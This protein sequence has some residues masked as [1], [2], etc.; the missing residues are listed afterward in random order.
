M[1][2]QHDG[3]VVA[4]AELHPC[5]GPR[6][7]VTPL[8]DKRRLPV[9]RRRRNQHHPAAL[10]GLLQRRRGEVAP[11][12]EAG[13]SELEASTRG[14]SGLVPEEATLLIA[15][16]STPPRFPGQSDFGAGPR[17]AG[18]RRRH[19]DA[20][21]A[22]A[23]PARHLVLNRLDD[24]RA[25]AH[26][27]AHS[28][29]TSGATAPISRTSRWLLCANQI[30]LP[31]A[32]QRRSAASGDATSRC[33]MTGHPRRYLSLIGRGIRENPIEPWGSCEVSGAS[34]RRGGWGAIA[35]RSPLRATV[36]RRRTLPASSCSSRPRSRGRRRHLGRAS[37]TP[38]R[39]RRSRDRLRRR[40]LGT[41]IS[42]RL[43][44]NEST[45]RDVP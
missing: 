23:R 22:Q 33:P 31:N 36:S 8:R 27:R 5:A 12:P 9:A 3:V 10:G 40:G 39:R 32:Q 29:A 30:P 26:R 1:G 43:A 18:L 28:P 20:V 42:A 34:N 17:L 44:D 45:A 7:Q 11:P 25:Y 21:P 16:P 14:N 6:I 41:A 4:R 13:R 37:R 15:P 38:G 24:E 2:E 19:E 35:T